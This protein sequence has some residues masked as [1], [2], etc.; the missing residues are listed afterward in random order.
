MNGSKRDANCISK[1]VTKTLP[2]S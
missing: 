1:G 2:K